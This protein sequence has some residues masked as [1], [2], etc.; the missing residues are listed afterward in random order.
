MLRRKCGSCVA[1]SGTRRAESTGAHHEYQPGPIVCALRAAFVSCAPSGMKKRIAGRLHENLSDVQRLE[2]EGQW[3]KI[4]GSPLRVLGLPAHAELDDVKQRYKDLLFETHP[5]TALAAARRA[6]VKDP[7]QYTAGTG[8]EGG[9]LVATGGL[10]DDDIRKRAVERFELLVEAHR[11]I[12][13]P[14]SLWHQ[15]GS[16]PQIYVALK[17][18]TFLSRVRDPTVAFALLAYALGAVVTAIAFYHVVPAAYE[19]L[20]ELCFPEFDAFMH[21]QEAEERRLRAMGIEPDVDPARLAPAEA[22][23]ILAPGKAL[24][25]PSEAEAQE[26]W[27]PKARKGST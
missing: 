11:Q 12:T 10:S 9:A 18:P 22:K 21:K 2:K 1:C 26:Q 24:L 7:A 19:K 23:H 6:G 17:P 13:N 14:A 27:Q 20:L 25:D 8:G 3:V 5:D 15:S 16:A 4:H